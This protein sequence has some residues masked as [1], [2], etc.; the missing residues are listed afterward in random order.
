[1]FNPDIPQPTDNL[2]VSQGDLLTNFQQLNTQFGVNHVPFDDSGSDKGKHK[3]VTFVEQSED[4][5]SKGDEYLMYSKEDS[6]SSELF[7]RPESNAPAF[8]FTKEGSV[9]VGAI[10][11][12]AVN[13]DRTGVIQGSSLNVTSVSRPGGTG[14]YVIN[15]TNALPDNNYFWNASGFDGSTARP[16]ISQVTNSASYGSV[17]TT[18]SISID[19][20]DNTNTLISGLTRASVICWRFQ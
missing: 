19:F 5:E 11:V 17:V 18:T 7:V 10:P 8:Q 3:F 13:F 2:S 16:V 9:F 15:F 20:K 1:M 6:G 14:T 4:P 12:V